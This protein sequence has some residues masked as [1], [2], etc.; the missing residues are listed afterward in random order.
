M[1]YKMALAVAMLLFACN[2]FAQHEP[3]TTWPYLYGDFTKG[4]IKSMKD[5]AK[6]GIFN[7]HILYGRLHFIEGELIREIDLPEH[8]ANICFGG[9]NRDILFITARSSVYTLK[10]NVVGVQWMSGLCDKCKTT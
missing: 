6:P 2:A 7:I 8:P 9:K 4:E 1:K 10:M 5:E 3:T